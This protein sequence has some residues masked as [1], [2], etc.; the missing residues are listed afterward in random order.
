MKQKLADA[1]F[2]KSGK[3]LEENAKSAIKYYIGLAVDNSTNKHFVSSTKPEVHTLNDAA[4]TLNIWAK[5]LKEQPEL[6]TDLIKMIETLQS[7]ANTL[8][9]L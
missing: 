1:I 5:S 7:T 8:R 4:F 2:E 9:E 3:H 6:Q